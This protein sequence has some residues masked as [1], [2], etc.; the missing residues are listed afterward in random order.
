L[1]KTWRRARRLGIEIGDSEND[2]HLQL[3]SLTEKLAARLPPECA[4]LLEIAAYVYAVDQVVRRGGVRDVDYGGRWR[5]RIRFEIP[6]RVPDLWSSPEVTNNLTDTLCELADDHPYEFRFRPHPAPPNLGKYLYDEVD[7]AGRDDCE[8]VVLFSGGI[9]SLAG[10]VQEIL[11]GRRR[12]ALVSHRSANQ[13]YSRQCDLVTAIT[14]RVPESRLRPLHV[15]V[16]VNSGPAID[17][18]FTQ[19][20]RSFLYV[21]AGAVVARALGRSRVRFYENGVTSLNLPMSPQIVGARAS[22]TTNPRVLAG[23]S[24]LLSA[25]FRTAF[26]VDNPFQWTTKAGVLRG[27]AAAGCADLCA[28]TVSCVETRHRTLQFPHCGK[29]SQ[30]LDRRLAAIAAEL[31]NDQDPPSGYESDVLTGRLDEQE[32]I[33]FES[34]I[35][36]ARRFAKMTD[37]R[38]FLSEC[39]EANRALRSFD[40]SPNEAA[41]HI[42][43]LCREHGAEIC[44]ALATALRGRG[45]AEIRQTNP[46]NCLLSIACNGENNPRFHPGRDDQSQS[47]ADAI[48]VDGRRFSVRQGGQECPIGNK[49]EYRLFEYLRERAGD[50]VPVEDLAD[51]V[52]GCSETRSNA[53]Q[54]VASNLRRLLRDSGIV[55]VEVD[56]SQDGYFRLVLPAT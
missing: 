17:G 5:R 52:W 53:I 33:L 44:R 47:N 48:I 16:V 49:L 22:Q 38:S 35:G 45:A 12:V 39:G 26:R 41:K 6:V 1:P 15:P 23:F 8:E 31:T 32:Q 51:D 40:M 9:D 46:P 34:Y 28:Q 14:D 29:C 4:D 30:C 13:V 21:A 25:V 37:V 24:K 43:K 36:I 19:R 55:G 11:V 27:L 18:E 2:V 7:P 42:F 10:A 3:G 50:Y 56:G 20:T 54:R